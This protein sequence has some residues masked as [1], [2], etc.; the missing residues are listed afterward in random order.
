MNE[1]HSVDIQA[2]RN[3]VPVGSLAHDSLQELAAEVR[4][5]RAAPGERLFE[6][7]DHDRLSFYVL[8]GSVALETA[9]G[10]VETVT[11]GTPEAKFP[12]DHHRPRQATARARDEVTYLRIDRER[13]DNMLTWEQHA[14][15][16]VTEIEVE[17]DDDTDGD[18]EED[19]SGDWMTNM[20]RSALFHRIPPA[21]IQAIFM[22][23]EAVP[24]QA[25]EE[26]IRQGEEGDYYYYIK[27]GRCE[28]T[29]ETKAGKT[30]RLAELEA[31]Q[32]FGEEALLAQTRRNATIT[33]LTDGVLM[34]LGKADFEALLKQPVLKRVTYDEGLAMVRE[35]AVWLD[36]RLESEHANSA[37]PGSINIPLYLL[38]MKAPALNRDRRY[39]VY[40]DSG[41]R[42]ASA[43]YLLSERGIDAYL[44]EGGLMAVEGEK[45]VAGA[46]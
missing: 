30:L 28:V 25:G 5:E 15:Y 36:V 4:P 45:T 6:C 8:K 12:L 23:M 18:A 27:Q 35:D 7:G 39:V 16:M 11:A 20:L 26:V 29:R 32:G 14:G 17:F 46:G 9:D 33:M 21:N 38:R 22:K 19:D 41:R 24:V 43:V 34:R 10:D 42:S 2:L 13:L 37:I 44:L 40:C 3:L 1:E 31:G